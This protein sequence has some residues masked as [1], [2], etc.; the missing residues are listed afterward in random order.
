MTSIKLRVEILGIK[1]NKFVTENVIIFNKSKV[2]G[3]FI[4]ELAEELDI[5]KGPESKKLKSINNIDDIKVFKEDYVLDLKKKISAV[6]KMTL[7]EQFLFIKNGQ[8]YQHLGYDFII[9]GVL[10]IVDPN[11]LL[12]E[13]DD[14]KNI[15]YKYRNHEFEDRS[16]DTLKNIFVE[17][18]TLFVLSKNLVFTQSS[19]TMNY[20]YKNFWPFDNDEVISY[21][22]MIKD[23]KNFERIMSIV[24]KEQIFVTK[25]ISY[26]NKFSRLNIDLGQM[27]I[28]INLKNIEAEFCHLH[29]ERNIYK[30]ITKYK[31]YN[32]FD[33]GLN[34]YFSFN[35]VKIIITVFS[36]GKIKITTLHK[37][38]N[39]A[40]VIS[41]LD[42]KVPKILKELKLEKRPLIFDNLN[43]TSTFN[44][45]ITTSLFS[46]LVNTNEALLPIITEVEKEND[47][48]TFLLYKNVHT[49]AKVLDDLNDED[50]KS[51]SL[52][53][54]GLPFS[55]INQYTKLLFKADDV[56]INDLEYV[57]KLITFYCQ[58]ILPSQDININFDKIN[59]NKRLQE[60]DPVA[61]P[62]SLNWARLC[63][64]KNQPIIFDE[65]EWALLPKDI[66]KKCI[67]YFNFTTETKAYYYCPNKQFPFLAFKD[68]NGRACPCCQKKINIKQDLYDEILKTH[69]FVKEDITNSRYETRYGKM[70]G[71][72][73]IIGLPLILKTWLHKQKINTSYKLLGISQQGGLEEI[74]KRLVHEPHNLILIKDRMEGEKSIFYLTNNKF[75]KTLPNLI[76]IDQKL[77]GQHTYYPLYIINNK[78]F[79]GKGIIDQK[80]FGHDDPLVKVF[81]SLKKDVIFEHIKKNYEI[82]KLHIYKDVILYVLIVYKKKFVLLPLNHP[83]LEI[84]S[85]NSLEVP[86]LDLEMPINLLLEVISFLNIGLNVD[87][88]LIHKK[89]QIGFL[90]NGLI[91]HHSPINVEDSEFWVTQKSININ[92]PLESI[93][94]SIHK[95]LPPSPSPVP[96]QNKHKGEIES[97]RTMLLNNENKAIRAK[98]AQLWPLKTNERLF[99]IYNLVGKE[100]YFIIKKCKLIEEVLANYYEFD[101][102]GLK[103][104]ASM[105]LADLRKK[106]SKETSEY[107]FRVIT[108][109]LLLRYFINKSS[110]TYVKN[111]ILHDGEKIIIK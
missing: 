13:Y 43:I 20:Y 34:I 45:A 48:Y 64:S 17:E 98:L 57:T 22:L 72:N 54:S 12:E 89:K 104:I 103:K 38:I 30:Y 81:L 56:N 42:D 108:N 2:G 35:K 96:K 83:I 66:N 92:Y 80:I 26:I 11:Q 32:E 97:F 8:G 50:S 100:D 27:M 59:K 6:T 82:A 69:I 46:G 49:R 79:N 70:P 106:Y 47:R 36:S 41:I 14:S 37:S 31:S 9:D 84:Q 61:Y 101:N 24:P 1:N 76:L 58:Q 28:N 74:I 10:Y 78:A 107:L 25:T 60:R 52:D 15:L 5:K 102:V 71:V 63:Q 105:T 67:E 75:E 95:N 23:T 16:Y 77:K 40:F 91:Y 3:S 86:N 44:M 109:P 39:L 110:D 90:S 18:S 85:S 55:I 68:V 21:D 7:G 19:D 4:S 88:V 65:K 33:K 87:R 93:Y 99:A 51:N 29:K 73:R 111:I 94:N 53:N 62:K